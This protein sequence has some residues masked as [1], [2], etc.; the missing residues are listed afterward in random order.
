MSRITKIEGDFM[1][2]RFEVKP[3]P[4]KFREIE[5]QRRDMLLEWYKENHPDTHAKLIDD[6]T[7]IEQY[8]QEDIDALEA[9]LNDVEFRAKYLRF[10]SEAS[11][12][13]SKPLSEEIWKSDDLEYGTI[14]EAWDFFTKRQ[15]VPK[16]GVAQ[17]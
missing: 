5:K 16:G 7:D 3:T 12:K 8:T 2:V 11:M 9:W 13:L 15:S 17:R 6:E 4:I 14:E 10:M 1:G